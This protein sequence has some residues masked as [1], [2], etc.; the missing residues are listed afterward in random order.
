MK[1]EILIFFK[2]VKPVTGGNFLTEII[3]FSIQT[4]RNEVARSGVVGSI[5]GNPSRTIF[6]PV[7]SACVGHGFYNRKFGRI[8]C[9]ELMDS[10]YFWEIFSCSYNPFF[11]T[12][13]RW[14][15]SYDE[16]WRRRS[17]RSGRQCDLLDHHF[18]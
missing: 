10:I 1:T 18:L 7:N 5:V 9:K 8:Q 17:Y 12:Y 3:R 15:G 6:E 2:D 14:I 16:I 13:D 11:S 4:S